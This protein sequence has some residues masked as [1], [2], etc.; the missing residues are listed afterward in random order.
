MLVA[1]GYE[2]F[3]VSRGNGFDLSKRNWTKF[4]PKKPFDYVIHLAQSAHYRDFPDGACDMMRI[5]IEATFELLE[6]NR[7]HCA[8]SFLFASTGT[9]YRQKPNA[10]TEKDVAAPS[11]FYGATKLCAEQL[12]EQYQAFFPTQIMRL[13]GVYGPGQKSMVIINLIE[14]ILRNK[15]IVL[16][17]GIGLKF[18][19]LF[20]RDCCQI[21]R[22]LI[23]RESSSST[24][25]N[26]AG[27]E[28][29][30]LREVVEKLGKLLN[31]TPRVT[32]TNDLET[33]LVANINALE[34]LF[35]AFEATALDVGLGKTCKWVQD[36]KIFC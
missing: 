33:N 32:T 26:V 21:I 3:E 2:I 27:K 17:N 29:V 18:N 19:P 25:L 10:I 11:S 13:F 6:W 14:K 12:I 9:V 5:N 35:P 34:D 7:K 8:G 23:K 36:Q 4:I 22:Y 24:I 15:K 30:E 20:I 1:E 28:I 31:V 16:A